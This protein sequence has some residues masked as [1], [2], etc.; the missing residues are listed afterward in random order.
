MARFQTLLNVVLLA[1]VLVQAWW[2][3]GR[4]A[5]DDPSG[6][7][8]AVTTAAG[9]AAALAALP[10]DPLAMAVMNRLQ[11][12]DARLAALEHPGASA[13]AGVPP[14]ATEA[15]DPRTFPQAD[16]RL[17]AMLPDRDLDA[18]DW[19]QW[20]AALAA[21]PPAEQASISAAFA[22][23]VNADRIRLRF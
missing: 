11:R 4:E 14:P 3:H 21:L 23:A 12:I 9:E 19:A 2:L 17:D 13:G 6:D 10:G 5:V 18:R 8:A 16:R 15:L 22:R 1:I 7:P 20:Q